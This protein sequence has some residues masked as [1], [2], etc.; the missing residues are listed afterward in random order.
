MAGVEPALRAEELAVTPGIAVHPRL[1]DP[2]MH[3]ADISSAQDDGISPVKGLAMA[4][5]EFERILAEHT[6]RSDLVDLH[7]GRRLTG[8]E[9]RSDGVLASLQ[10]GAGDVQQVEARYL[11]AADGAN[12]TIRGLLGIEMDGTEELD[13]RR[14]SVSARTCRAGPA[15]GRAAFT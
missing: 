9:V 14:T 4:Q 11:I 2:A 10:D 6:L 7:R 3:V 8:I 12:S 5:D 1:V 13:R 15:S